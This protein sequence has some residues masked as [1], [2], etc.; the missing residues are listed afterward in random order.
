MLHDRDLPT[1]RPSLGDAARGVD[2]SRRVL[3]ET[4]RELIAPAWALGVRASALRRPRRTSARERELLDFMA[5][6]AQRI[7]RVLSGAFDY[8]YLD[9][10]RGIPVDPRPCSLEDVCEAALDEL[11]EAGVPVEV[12]YEADGD[13]EGEWDP[14]RLSQ[15]ISYLIE[16][17]ATYAASSEPITVRW[18]GD[19]EEVFIRVQAGRGGIPALIEPD[20]GEH[21]D[22]RLEGGVRA[23]LARRI[24]LAHGGVL[25]RLVAQ[26]AVSFIVVLP[27]RAPEDP[28]VSTQH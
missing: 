3:E 23:F 28:E 13:G 24:V 4:A 5:V 11:R 8:L 10:E 7:A 27:R 1:P 18:R 16:V 19:A 6:H 14:G 21:V 15:A 17:A 2:V 22:D 9:G 25:A 12:S 26:D 20:W